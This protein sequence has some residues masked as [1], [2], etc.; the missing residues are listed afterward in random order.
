MSSVIQGEEA[1]EI[2]KEKCLSLLIIFDQLCVKNNIRYWMDGG[3]ML[4]A[5]RH[6]GFIP[7]DDD[8]DLCIPAP[9][10]YKLIE[11]LG[12]FCK[13]DNPYV[14]FHGDTDFNFCFDFFGDVSYLVDGVYPIRID[15]LPVKVVENNP[16]AIRIDK[17]WANIAGIYFRGYPKDEKYIIPEH[18]YLMPKGNNLIKEK[19]AFFKLYKEYML[20]SYSGSDFSGKLI[21]Y[22]V[23]D[24]LVPKVREYYRYDDIFPLQRL[25]FEGYSLSAVNNPDAYLKLLYNKYMELPPVESQ[26]SHLN[27]LQ[28]NDLNK[29]QIKSFLNDFYLMGFKNFAITKRDNRFFR[30]WIRTYTF[31]YLFLKYSCKFQFKTVRNLL[32]YVKTK[33]N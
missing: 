23:N 28:K 29:K 9:D 2:A 4:G 16:E 19:D 12:D 25:P 22:S 1:I 10:Y 15:L 27:T 8:I 18:A 11:L 21:N 17:S 26:V 6:K 31:V 7:W 20:E 3:T 33:V 14:L 30:K 24:L 32:S 13:D 5:I